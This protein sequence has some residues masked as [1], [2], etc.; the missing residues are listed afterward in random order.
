MVT[1]NKKWAK[2]KR[3]RIQDEMYHHEMTHAKQQ[4]EYGSFFKWFMRYLFSRPFR[5]NQEIEGYGQQ[6]LFRNKRNHSSKIYLVRAFAETVIKGYFYFGRYGITDAE[7]FLRSYVEEND[8][9]RLGVD[10]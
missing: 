3:L 2:M 1:T 5:F 10:A 8:L 6:I 4:R 7:A 9:Y